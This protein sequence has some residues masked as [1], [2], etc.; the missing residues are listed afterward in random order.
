LSH[1]RS[2]QLNLPIPL[3]AGTYRELELIDSWDIGVHRIL[4]YKIISKKKIKSIHT[5]A[6]I[7]QYYAQWRLDHNQK[8]ELLLR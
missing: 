7:H 5:L 8:T 3:Q 1:E 2:D 4:I 6:H